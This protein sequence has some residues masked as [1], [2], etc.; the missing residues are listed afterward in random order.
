VTEIEVNETTKELRRKAE[1]KARK[2]ATD[3]NRF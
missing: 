3:V 2:E 1:E